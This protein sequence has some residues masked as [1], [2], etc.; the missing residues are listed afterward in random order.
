VRTDDITQAVLAR[1]DVARYLGEAVRAEP[2]ARQ[3]LESY[4]EE[5][6]TTQRYRF[7]RAL[8]HPLYPILRKVERIAEGLEHVQA[9]A[10]ASSTSRTTRATS[11]IW[12]SH[13][14]STTTGFVR[15][16]R[17]PA[18]TSSAERSA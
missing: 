2:D 17:R 9:G 11:T 15:R 1:D 18:S 4:L 14:S 13:W 6:R 5:L 12:S 3:R 10:A 16:L 8:Q 7:Y